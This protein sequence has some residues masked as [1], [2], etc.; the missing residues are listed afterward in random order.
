M[1]YKKYDS[2]PMSTA[3]RVLERC[4]ILEDRDMKI[5]SE[6]QVRGVRTGATWDSWG[7]AGTTL[8]SHEAWQRGSSSWA[9]RPTAEIRL[10]ISPVR[11]AC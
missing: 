8:H 2:Y 6:S 1:E 10:N 5:A 9:A 3:C 7:Q 11:S 4:Q